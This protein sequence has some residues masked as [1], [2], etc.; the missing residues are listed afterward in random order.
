MSQ[1][2]SSGTVTLLFTDLVGSTEGRGRLGEEAAEALRRTHDRLLA[3]AIE[4]N[5][6]Q[7][8]KH[9]GDGVMATFTGAA[10]A[11]SAAVGAQR[12]VAR[13]NRSAEGAE[14][15]DMR[16]GLS[17]G[18]VTFEDGDVFGT[19]VIEAA[20]LCAAARGGQILAADVVR[21]LA[22]SRGGHRFTPAGALEL[23]GLPAPLAAA[24]IAWE[25]ASG[26]SI[27]LPVALSRP[28]SFRFV[29]REEEVEVLTRAWKEAA[30]GELRGLLVSGEAGVGKTRLVAEAARRFHAEGSVVLFGRCEEELGV[31]YQPFAEALCDYVAA[32]P[33]DELRSQLG[34]L[35]GELT[36]LVPNLPERVPGLAA[37]L[38]AE[39]ETER[40]RLF[41]AVRELL[42]AISDAAPVV[43][44]LD[45]LHWAARPTLALLV[46]LVRRAEAA[47]LLIVGTYRD[48]DLG[49]TDPLAGVLAD[50]RRSSGT[51][52]IAL[53]GLDEA[54]AVGFIEA[55]TGHALT[56][57]MLTL[58]RA[59][60]TE[61]EGNPFFLGEVVRHLFEAGALAEVDGRW[62]VVRPVDQLGIPEGVREVVGRR[63]SRLPETVN[64]VLAT[65]AVI[66]REFDMALL[67]DVVDADADEV[68]NAVEQAEAARLVIARRGRPGIYAFA[69]ALVRSTLYEEL[70]STGRLRLH[71]R[72]GL[73]ME[74]R[75]GSALPELAR[76]FV[77]AAPLGESARAVDYARQAGD[78]ARDGLAMEEAATHYERALNALEFSGEGDPALR[79]DL[80]IARGDAL[81]RARD[82][83]YR[84]VLSEVADAARTLGDPRRLAWVAVTHNLKFARPLGRMEEEVI[85]LAEEALA[86]LPP[87][88]DPLR[89]RLLAVLAL[90][91]AWSAE[92]GRRRDLLQNAWEMAR[93]LDDA[94]VLADVLVLRRW[95]DTDPENLSARLAFAAKLVALGEQL[96]DAEATCHG[97]IWLGMCHYEDLDTTALVTGI[98]TAAALAG[99]LRQPLLATEVAGGRTMNAL[100]FG[101]LDE[102][103]RLMVEERDL[104]IEAGMPART[105]LLFFASQSFVLRYEQGRAQD[106]LE[107]LQPA[108]SFAAEAGTAAWGWRA[109]FGLAYAEAGDVASAT[110]VLE[111]LADMGFSSFTRNAVWLGGTGCLGRLAAAV[112]NAERSEAIYSLLAPFAGRAC[113]MG[114]IVFGPVDPVLGLL[115]ATA[116]QLDV[117]HDH[118]AA[119]VDLCHRR[120]LP[121]WLARS[122]QEW[123]EMLVARRGP[124]DTEQATELATE[125]LTAAE[126]LGMAGV[127]S[128]ARGLLATL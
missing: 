4:T 36:R 90:E 97:Q 44:V 108:Q 1:A 85:G 41:E 8:V 104:G 19:P 121:T 92:S 54:A 50:L 77:E 83:R 55:L 33:R 39:P 67:T 30:A 45:D 51:E 29:G 26:S 103:A 18:D 32:V 65:A 28:G 49:R 62:H 98:E 23:K 128:R 119:A 101:R 126:S 42:T 47:R 21:V 63:L 71:R 15:L 5:G 124:G 113:W 27:P 117:A 106:A 76:H 3:S 96:D 60:W 11:L 115:A 88:D 82:R 10:D 64:E 6:G 68:L 43:L 14:R 7:V 52:R 73:A 102:A 37:P 16:V 58:T 31:P 127:A 111:E 125:A 116:G 110:K 79:C 69:H 70:P 13:H 94:R 87:D 34:S 105:V 112:G 118:F 78:R 84:K 123:A 2:A 86:A 114:S 81:Y 25:A 109:I 57:D 99:Q 9:L 72:V 120:G 56:D 80:L 59:V 66:G 48:T 89:A 75:V 122:Q 20:R 17:A 100:V 61:T 38:S 12:A 24:E 40:Y 95:A 22:G 91:L 93:R 46:H 74:R 35:G 107:D 53:G